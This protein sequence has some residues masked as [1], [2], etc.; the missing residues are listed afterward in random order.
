VLSWIT[1]S[2]SGILWTTC[3]FAAVLSLEHGGR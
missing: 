1:G 2:A 3:S